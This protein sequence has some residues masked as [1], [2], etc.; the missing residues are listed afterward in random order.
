MK[1]IHK[2]ILLFTVSFG[3]ILLSPAPATQAAITNSNASKEAVCD[4]VNGC[5]TGDRVEN[6]IKAIINLVTTIV[7]IIAVIMIIINGFRFITS[8]GDSNAVT[9]ARNG[10]IYAIIGLVVVVL[11][12]VIVRFV[13]ANV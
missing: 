1:L 8:G 6:A 9:S 4:G 12:Q 10:L 5:G 11:A 3:L 2:L 13:L 7:G